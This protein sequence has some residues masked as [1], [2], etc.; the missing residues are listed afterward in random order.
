M[1]PGAWGLLCV[2]V[3]MHACMILSEAGHVARLQAAV[4]ARLPQSRCAKAIRSQVQGPLVLILIECH[5]P[6]S[7]LCSEGLPAWFY[8]NYLHQ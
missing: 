3:H 1:A 7:R 5:L 4:E 6:P 8:N 2:C